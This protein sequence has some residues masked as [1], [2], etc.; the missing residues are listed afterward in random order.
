VISERRIA[1]MVDKNLSGLPPFPVENGG[2]NSGLMIPQYTAASIV[3]GNKV[4]SHPASAD[5]IPTSANQ[6]DVNSI[7]SV[8][9]KKGMKIVENT[10]LVVAIE[11][12]TALQAL[13]LSL[14]DHPDRKSSPPLEKLRRECREKIPFLKEDCYLK[15]HLDAALKLIQ[16]GLD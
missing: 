16:G 12:L 7:G 2:L 1:R 4:L 8:A 9:G 15:P 14:K 6:E 3:S 13:D 5:S 11:L 10:E